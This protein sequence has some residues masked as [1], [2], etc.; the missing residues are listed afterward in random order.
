M[1]DH[2]LLTAVFSAFL[3]YFFADIE[4]KGNPKYLQ[5]NEE[6]TKE[7]DGECDRPKCDF[8]DDSARNADEGYDKHLLKQIKP[9]LI[10]ENT[11][12]AVFQCK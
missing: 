9:M 8:I 5:S 12:N 7:D 6:Q 10:H 2:Y 1:V 3:L 11:N 4:D